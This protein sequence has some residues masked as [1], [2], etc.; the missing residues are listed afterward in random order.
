MIRIGLFLLII[1]LGSFTVNGQTAGQVMFVGFNADGNG[2]F[3]FVTF[4]DLANGSIL[5]FNDN[6]W[7]GASFDS[8]TDGGT[9]DGS[10]TWTNNT[11]STISAGTVITINNSATTPVASIGATSGGTIDLRDQNE[12]LYMFIGAN[13]STPTTFYQPLRMMDILPQMDL[14]PLH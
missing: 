12:V 3:S 11:T 6:E 5:R 14:C 2:G 4:V 9:P 1:L 13:A 8:D 7:G 10:I